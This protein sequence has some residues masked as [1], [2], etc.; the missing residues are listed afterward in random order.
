MAF[1][2]IYALPATYDTQPD[3]IGGFQTFDQNG[4]SRGYRP[5][6]ASCLMRDM[7]QAKFCPVDIENMWLQFFKRVQLIDAVELT[8]EHVTVRY[9]MLSG[10]TFA[11]YR[12]DEASKKFLLLDFPADASRLV[13]NGLRPGRYKVVATFRTSEI[14]KASPVSTQEFDVPTR[15]LSAEL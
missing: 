1:A 2:N 10:L 6:H 13:R 11:W 7:R 3:L 4:R 9:P 8:P 14:R 15:T 5:T 12:K